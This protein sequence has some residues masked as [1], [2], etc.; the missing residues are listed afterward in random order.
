MFEEV[1]GSSLLHAVYSPMLKNKLPYLIFIL[2]IGLILIGGW[3]FYV[4]LTEIKQSILNLNPKYLLISVL[5]YLTAYFIRSVRWNLLIQPVV[6]LSI[7]ESWLYAL[8]G[9]FT[10]YL[11]PLRLGEL[12]KAWFVKKR[13][14]IAMVSSLPSIFIDKSFDTLGII[15]VLSILPF[16]SIKL[17]TAMVVL[18]TI[19]ILVFVLSLALI[20]GAA[21]HKQTSAKYLNAIFI[22][23]PAKLRTKVNYYVELFIG[24][25]NI[26]DHHWSRLVY[27]LLL[28]ILGVILD[29]VYFY[30][31][32]LA[33]GTSISFLL[34][35]FGYTLINLSY[36]LPQPPAQLGS[37]EWM[38]IVIFSVGFGL[39]AQGVS[40]IMA[41]A[42]VMTAVIISLGGMAAF[43][44]TGTNIL[45]MIMKG[46]NLND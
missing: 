14:G 31:V 46:E 41:T 6:K 24:G 26:F 10:N 42:H 43:S 39:T 27:A 23:L 37:N 35:L 12:V 2:M 36:A 28:T 38:M 29:G 22:I 40:A 19:L 15:V 8:G 25:L 3:I 16:V 4:D 20:V 5:I 13:H 21:L 7:I 45:R 33:F 34:L 17:S 9:N 30:L 32:F 11:I 44:Y 18:L 1:L